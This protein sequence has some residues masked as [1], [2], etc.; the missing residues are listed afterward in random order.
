[1]GSKFLNVTQIASLNQ[2]FFRFKSAGPPCVPF[3]Q[4]GRGG[5]SRGA[6]ERPVL[7]MRRGAEVNL[8]GWKERSHAE[9]F[10]FKKFYKICVE[11]KVYRVAQQD[12]RTTGR[13]DGISHMKW[14]ETKQQLI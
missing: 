8:G 2:V 1:M 5:V 7:V 3:G 9:I 10:R 12:V 11:N 14:K 4:V 6:T 13:P